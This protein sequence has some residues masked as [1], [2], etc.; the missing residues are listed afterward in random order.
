V[1]ARRR[2]QKR[3]TM[4]VKQIIEQEK[5]TEGTGISFESKGIV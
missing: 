3:I 1:T 4:D 5:Q 2:G